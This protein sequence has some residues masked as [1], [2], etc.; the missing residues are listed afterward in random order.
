MKCFASG[1]VIRSISEFDEEQNLKRYTCIVVFLIS[2]SEVRGS[3]GEG[4]IC[5][6]VKGIYGM[7]P[8]LTT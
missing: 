5:V 7:V 4:E 3:L 1:K 2:L 8:L 6:T